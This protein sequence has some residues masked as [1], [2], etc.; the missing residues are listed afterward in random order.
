MSKNCFDHV[1]GQHYMNS[2][3]KT[4]IRIVVRVMVG[5]RVG[6]IINDK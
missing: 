5:F 3:V 2:I 1:K 4:R 6:N